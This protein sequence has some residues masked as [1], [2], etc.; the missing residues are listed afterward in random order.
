M[1]FSK[2]KNKNPV[3]FYMADGYS[4]QIS[5]KLKQQSVIM[6]FLYGCTVFSYEKM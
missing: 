3:G 6:D 1:C 2:H 4:A 5:D